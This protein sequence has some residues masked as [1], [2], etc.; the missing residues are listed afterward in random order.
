MAA[1]PTP[2]SNGM[3]DYLRQASY[4]LVYMSICLTCVV[5]QIINS[6]MLVQ[7]SRKLLHFAVLF[8]VVLAFIVIFCS[9]LNPLTD[10][11]CE[12]VSVIKIDY[13]NR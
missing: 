11:S 6:V 10:V 8:E 12:V 2:E 1:E 5:W 4:T 3:S 9:L 7:R 13:I